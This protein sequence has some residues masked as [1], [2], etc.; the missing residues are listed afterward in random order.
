MLLFLIY[1]GLRQLYLYI[2]FDFR[3]VIFN[4][5][6]IFWLI[7]F[8]FHLAWGG[9]LLNNF[10]EDWIFKTK[11]IFFKYQILNISF[12]C[13]KG[14][15]QWLSYHYWQFNKYNNNIIKIIAIFSRKKIRTLDTYLNNTEGLWLCL[16]PLI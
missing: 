12:F 4:S 8:Y 2:W 10:L 1:I 9:S 13:E 16:G 11:I 3:N 7:S 6:R 14:E 15:R 5:F